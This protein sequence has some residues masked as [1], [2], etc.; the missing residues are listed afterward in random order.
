MLKGVFIDL[1]PGIF[2]KHGIYALSGVLGAENVELDYVSTSS[3]ARAVRRVVEMRPDF[4]MYSALSSQIGGYQ[5]FDAQ[6][7]LAIPTF[8]I[9]GGAGPTFSPITDGSIDAYVIGEGESALRNY[10]RNGPENAGNMVLRGHAR[11]LR[12]EPFIDLELTPPPDRSVVYKRDKVLRN[13]PSKQFMSGLG[14]PFSCT[15][16]FNHAYNQMTKSCGPTIRK[17]SV[18]RLLDEVN[19]TK[20]LYPFNLAVFQDDVFTINKKWFAEFA[21]RFPREAKIPYTCNIRPDMVD[22]ETVEMLASS[23]CIGVHWSIESGNDR[24]RNEV[25]RR[26]M[27]KEQIIEAGQLLSAAGIKQRVGHLIGIPGE[28]RSEMLETLELSQK[29]AP[30]YSCA[31]IFIPFPGLDLT[32]SAIESGYLSSGDVGDLPVN[33][34]KPSAL[35]MDKKERVWMRKFSFLFPVFVEHPFLYKNVKLQKVAFSIPTSVL[36]AGFQVLDSLKMARLYKVKVP[37]NHT[38]KMAIRVIRQA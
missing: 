15:Y 38:I 12:L 18:D 7:K 2:D 5:A 34:H 28:S 20:R 6:L 17:K 14:C 30:D 35:K 25:L 19:S 9:I 3:H 36:W 29:V 27:S 1:F 8:S 10:V 21:Q 37:L 31:Y 16:C 26:K 32:N 4:V 33:S 11:P 22:R 23:G 24:I 13:A